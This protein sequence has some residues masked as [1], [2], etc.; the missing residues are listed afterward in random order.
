MHQIHQLA[1]ETIA[2]QTGLAQLE[3]ILAGRDQMPSMAV[4]LGFRLSAVEHGK[5]V[6]VGDPSPGFMNVLGSVHGGWT[7]SIMDSAL[8]C[9]VHT[10]L[11][12]GERYATLELKVNL[13]RAILPDMKGLT[14]VG[15]VVT[16]GRRTAVSE[17][18]LN[19]ADGKVYATGS[20]TCMILSEP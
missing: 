12:P 7:A 4:S 6:F 5:A 1:D 13:T 10:T 19:G 15:T 2:A 17:A 14:A 16:R 8:G 11:V 9:A 3:G 20:S 18:R